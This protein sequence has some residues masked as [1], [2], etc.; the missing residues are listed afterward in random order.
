MS[1]DI[2]SRRSRYILG[3]RLETASSFGRE[4]ENP[5]SHL[6]S[7]IV[8]RITIVPHID[9]RHRSVLSAGAVDGPALAA[10]V[11]RSARAQT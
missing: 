6:A 3:G 4:P 9:A 5:Q 11:F 10:V 2:R 7:N 1:L 8:V